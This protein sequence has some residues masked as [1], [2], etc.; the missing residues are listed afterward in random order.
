MTAYADRRERLVPLMDEKELDLLL[1]TNLVNVRYLCGFA[2][3]NGVCV[4]GREDRIFVTD[5]RYV[6][7]AKTE[8]GDFEIARGKR[9]LLDSVAELVGA[10][11]GASRVGFDE[12]DMT[13]KAHGSLASKLPDPV[14]LVPAGG[15]VERLRAVKDEAELDS[16]RQA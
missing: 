14:T 8:V 2:G 12:D 10:R 7:R 13:V 6:E 4:L 15:L 3:T 16:I 5:F 11:E 9:N 1:V